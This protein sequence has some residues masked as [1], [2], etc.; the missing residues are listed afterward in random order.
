MHD[1]F[2]HKLVKCCCFITTQIIWQFINNL[3][4][5]VFV[6]GLFSTFALKDNIRSVSS[7]ILQ[8]DELGYFVTGLVMF[9]P[10]SIVRPLLMQQKFSET[11]QEN[12]V[13]MNKRCFKYTTKV[14]TTITE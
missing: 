12:E 14:C 4:P 7:N 6:S 8:F 1:L 5:K 13:R 2:N 3:S 9:S 10:E 11:Q